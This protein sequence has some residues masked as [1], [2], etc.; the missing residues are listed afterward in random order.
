MSAE[1]PS[2]KTKSVNLSAKLALFGVCTALGYTYF[3]KKYKPLKHSPNKPTNSIQLDTRNVVLPKEIDEYFSVAMEAALA[4]GET[5]KKFINDKQSKSKSMVTKSTHADIVTQ[6]DKQCENII[7]SK[8]CS[9]FP[10]HKIIAEESCKDPNNHNITNDATWFVDP[11]DG[12]TNFVHGMPIVAVSIGLRINKIPILGI[13][14]CPVLGETF[15]AILS[16][17]SFMIN[18]KT[19]KTN[20]L[21]TNSIKFDIKESMKRALI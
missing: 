3:C 10:S 4:A 21:Q 6:I 15:H 13:V 5:I 1:D 20:K 19:N 17:G 12:T 11:I 14:H 8:I 9:A 18:H 2:K 7:L 16:R